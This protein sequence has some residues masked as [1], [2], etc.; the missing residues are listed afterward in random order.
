MLPALAPLAIPS[1]PPPAQCHSTCKVSR[2]AHACAIGRVHPS[3]HGPQGAVLLTVLGSDI[4]KL[5]E[6]YTEGENRRPVVLEGGPPRR[7]VGRCACSHCG[8]RNN[9]WPQ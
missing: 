4:H 2:R 3:R 6:W 9:G 5:K 7:W 8:C 1:T